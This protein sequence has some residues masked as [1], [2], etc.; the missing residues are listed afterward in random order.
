VLGILKR[1][2]EYLETRLVSQ[3]TKLREGFSGALEKTDR[4]RD[5]ALQR[6]EQKVGAQEAAQAKLDRKISELGGAIRGLSEEMQLQIRRVDTA[7]SR[8]WEFRHSLE[9][10]LRQRCQDLDTKQQETLSKCRVLMAAGDEGQKRLGQ[11][12]RR[13]DGAVQGILHGD[14]THSA[15]NALQERLIVLEEET[16][17]AKEKLHSASREIVASESATMSSRNSENEA[18]L[19]QLEHHLGEA[20]QKL[21]RLFKETH[22]DRGWE[23]RLEEHE[24]RL[25]GLRARLDGQEEHYSHF[26]ERFRH[27]WEARFE[28]LR[29]CIQDT[30]TRHHQSS[31]H[32][33][34][35]SRRADDVDQALEDLHLER[36]CGFLQYQQSRTLEYPL[37]Y[38]SAR[39]LSCI[40]E[41]VVASSPPLCEASAQRGGMIERLCGRI[42]KLRQDAQEALTPPRSITPVAT[43]RCGADENN[44]S[45]GETLLR[46]IAPLARNGLAEAKSST[47][48]LTPRGYPNDSISLESNT[49]WPGALSSMPNNSITTPRGATIENSSLFSK[50]VVPPGGELSPR[51]TSAATNANP[52]V[53][54]TSPSSRPATFPNASETF[55]QPV[56]T[57]RLNVGT[58]P[59]ARSEIM[60]PSCGTE[61][62]DEL[63]N[64]FR[65]VKDGENECAELQ[66]QLKGRI[67]AVDRLLDRVS[68]EVLAT[69]GGPF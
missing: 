6:L 30:A 22:G 65:S 8:L 48:V 62:G 59:S 25:T 37:E 23:A 12:M 61:D 15:L 42:D 17:H 39:P 46:S 33:E 49:S 7:D 32:L 24:V 4:I 36:P 41:P 55:V 5:T 54:T 20:I 2:M 13:L 43:P 26:D 18:R 60:M 69:P 45:D 1:E 56:M 67:N 57:P 29:K 51:A 19:W 40:A 53:H 68:S 44:S 10:E 50:S 14:A 27:D 16:A 63:A 21:D 28:Q 66:Q 35:L 34:K 52:L 58:E 38:Q 3:L 11:H 47:S 31:E 64:L 9:E